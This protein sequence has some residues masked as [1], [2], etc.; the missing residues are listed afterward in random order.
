MRQGKVIFSIVV[1]VLFLLITLPQTAH[2]QGAGNALDFDGADDY[3][4]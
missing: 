4:A 3:V 1:V 2:A